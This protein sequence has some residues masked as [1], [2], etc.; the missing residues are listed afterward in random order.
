MKHVPIYRI[1]LLVLVL[2]GVSA[3]KGQVEVPGKILGDFRKSDAARAIY[4]LPPADPL[5][6]DSR[7]ALN[8]ERGAKNLHYAILRP[9]DLNPESHGIWEE[10][11]MRIWR[12]HII[13]PGARSLGL[14]FDH[15]HLKEGVHL[16]IYDPSRTHIRGAYSAL[17]NK[18]SGV[19]AVGHIPGEELILELQVPAGQ[20]EFGELS[21]SALS[22]AFLS[23]DAVKAGLSC[24]GEYGCSGE[25]EID[26]NC[27]EGAG[28]QRQKR[29]IIRVNTLTQYCTGVLINNTYYN[30]DP[31]LLTA[32]HCIDKQ[33]IAE[34]TVY[35]FGY[36]S[37]S[38]SGGDGSLDNSIST[39]S[40]L[41]VGDSLD[42]CLLR[43]SS[44]PPLSY[45]AFYSGWNRER[46]QS[47]GT[48][49]L[50]HPEGDVK[51][52]SFDKDAP[53]LTND[54]FTLPSEFEEYI[55]SS[56]WQIREWEFGTTEPGSSG[57]PVYNSDKQVYG[58]LSWGYA[59]CR[60]PEDDFYARF[61]MAW[62]YSPEQ[63]KSLKFWLDPAGVDVMS[64]GGFKP[65]GIK[66]SF[67][68]DPHAFKIYPNPASG[69]VFLERV[70]S[71]QTE[72]VCRILDM[73]GR[74]LR[75][76]RLE[77]ADR[78]EI[79]VGDLT[80]GIYFLEVGNAA[81]SEFHKL[82]VE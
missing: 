64:I 80:P 15:F 1:I 29:S 11:E 50:H 24:P 9:V 48:H 34:T 82:V 57:S 28:W 65:V 21:L 52:I 19:L 2:T 63:N 81:W 42:F 69:Q 31:L 26:V 6:I 43:L 33:E 46:I 66:P 60:N 79:H 17:N 37:P 4:L 55:D 56:F 12:V 78:H 7:R 20:E 75:Q 49:T 61:D 38:C 18:S 5:E 14:V 23:P 59:T 22:H 10:E 47:A 40:L 76:F 73:G 30:G 68:P 39:A 74:T 3:L 58:L 8:A 54:G 77:A 70:E 45:D 25:C 16:M 36:E 41:A 13:S 32:K 71:G 67:I 72:F 27:E 62:D 44:Y 53:L 51:K 35:E